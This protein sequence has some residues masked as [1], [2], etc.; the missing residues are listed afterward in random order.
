MFLGCNVHTDGWPAY[1]NLGNSLNVQHSVVNHSQSFRDPVTGACIN[2]LEG[3]WTNAKDKFKR[4]RGTTRKHFNLYLSEV[5]WR[6]NEIGFKKDRRLAFSKLVE[7][8]TQ[9]FLFEN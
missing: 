3:S 6:A 7:V 1:R 2:E 4:M 8:L 5:M 9:K